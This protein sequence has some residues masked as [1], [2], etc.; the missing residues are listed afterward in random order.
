MLV[1]YAYRTDKKS[2]TI[3]ARSSIYLNAISNRIAAS[4]P[5]ARF[6]GMVVGT[7]MSKLIDSEDKRMVFSAEE[8]SGSDGQWYACLTDVNDRIG[9]I[10]D[11]KPTQIPTVKSPGKTTQLATRNVKPSRPMKA[12]N[13]S[14]KIISIEEIGNDSESEVEDLPTYEKP[15]SDPSDEDEDPTLVQRSKP[16]APV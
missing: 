8:L 9:S 1:G 7:A 4:S 3:L 16:T 14:S 10:S 5:R 15:D 12:L 6:L 2:L 11:L 13:K